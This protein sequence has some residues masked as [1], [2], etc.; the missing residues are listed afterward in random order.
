MRARWWLGVAMV[1]LVSV[2]C[3]ETPQTVSAKKSDVQASL[4]TASAYAAVGWKP[5]DQ[6]S[7]ERQMTTRAQG[8]NEYSRISAP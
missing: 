7:W 1:V 5:G 2:A 3:G 6:A 8:Q 4:G